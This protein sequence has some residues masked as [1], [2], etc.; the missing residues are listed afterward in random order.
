MKL[1]PVYPFT[2]KNESL[3]VYNESNEISLWTS[4]LLDRNISEVLGSKMLYRRKE[5]DRGLSNIRRVSL[6]CAARFGRSVVAKYWRVFCESGIGHNQART[7][8]FE[9]IEYMKIIS[10][11]LLYS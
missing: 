5:E 7:Q 4:L 1:L 8:I 11:Y 2:T 3:E 6:I 9:S 10:E